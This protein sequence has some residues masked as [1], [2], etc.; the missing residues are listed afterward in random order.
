MLILKMP[1]GERHGP[2][3]KLNVVET[4]VPLTAH[5]VGEVVSMIGK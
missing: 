3:F 2:V 4:G 1:E 5:R